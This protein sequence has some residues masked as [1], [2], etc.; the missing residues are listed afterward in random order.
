MS[1]GSLSPLA[2]LR[3]WP[4]EGWTATRKRRLPSKGN[5]NSQEAVFAAQGVLLRAEL[6]SLRDFTYV[7]T[8]R[9]C[10]LERVVQD[11]AREIAA[12]KGEPPDQAPPQKT[13]GSTV[14][15]HGSSAP[16]RAS[17]TEVEAEAV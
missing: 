1:S 9:V 6:E 8:E 14:S 16:S 4:Q 5:A 17:S 3:R 10:S 11:Q 7:L 15:M 2:R 12:L 13:L